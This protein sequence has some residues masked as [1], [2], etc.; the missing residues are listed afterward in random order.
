MK[1]ILFIVIL[2][3]LSCYIDVYAV[4]HL[5]VTYTSSRYSNTTVWYS[6]IPSK[7]KMHY[8]Y[9][10]DV[11]GRDEAP[12][13]NAARHNATVAINT[14]H[15]GAAKIEGTQNLLQKG[16]NV[17]A[18]DFYVIEN[19]S[20]SYSNYAAGAGTNVP[21]LIAT[22]PKSS[23]VG[24]DLSTIKN[25]IWCTDVMCYVPLVVNGS[26]VNNWYNNWQ[27]I[28]NGTTSFTG[29]YISGTTV[30]EN[31]NYHDVLTEKHPRSWLA[32]DNEG[33]QFV[34]T[35]GGRSSTEAGFDAKIYIM[36]QLVYSLVIL[37][38]YIC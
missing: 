3:L 22:N 35:C 7:Y 24:I 14:Q 31:H 38:I 9:G 29:R 20:D 17:S 25:P 37:N 6:I 28:V 10:G 12:S 34:A 21:H 13:A 11:V 18:Y 8:S 19:V 16:D 15:M 26:I 27:G 4:D 5:P 36:Q 1:K 32:I 33:N 30:E 2:F 23:K